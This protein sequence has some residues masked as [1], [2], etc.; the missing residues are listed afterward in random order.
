MS[1]PILTA[2]GRHAKDRPSAAA[3]RDSRLTLTYG[4]LNGLV[5]D[6]AAELDTTGARRILLDADN[7]IPWAV[8]DLAAMTAGASLTPIPGFF[9]SQQVDHVARET[10]A[11]LVLASEERVHRWAANEA[12]EPL[13]LSGRLRAY[14]RRGS[15]SGTNSPDPGASKITFTSGSTGT[16]RGVVLDN[17]VI[18]RSS[19]AIVSR[20]APLAPQEHLSVLPLATLLENIAGLYA[21]LI[22]GSAVHLPSEEET[23]LGGAALDTQRFCTLIER[24]RADTMILVPQ[25]LTALVTLAELELVA[26]PTFRLIAVGGGRVSRGLLERASQLGLP[27]C[28]GYGLSEACSVLT[29]NLPGDQRVGSVGRPLPHARLRVNDEG[30]IEVREPLMEGYL[31]AG[32]TPTRHSWY[33]TGDLGHFDEDGFLY[34]DGRR[35]NVFI[36]AFGRNVNPEWPEAALTQ[37]AAIG[38][39]LVVGEGRTHN[40]ALLWLRFELPDDAIQDIVDRANA[41]LPDYA[42]IHRWVTVAE[43]LAD[44]LQTDNGRLRRDAVLERYAAVIDAHYAESDG[45]LSTYSPTGAQHAVL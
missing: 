34:I 23:G 40:L 19:A 16:P 1:N 42:G 8:A 15:A 18:A 22:H 6:H 29:L 37:H 43:A 9:S 39:A 14:R 35:R 27:V 13:D 7:G 36:T 25:L 33:A 17:E 21:P 5:S 11:E 32:T 44:S 2:L 31:T 20:L 30:E 41:E 12:W 38:Q 26:L 4:A 3:L 24:S 45:P 28:E 10:G